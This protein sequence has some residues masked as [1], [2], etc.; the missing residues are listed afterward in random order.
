MDMTTILDAERRTSERLL[1]FIRMIQCK[2][3]C[4]ICNLQFFTKTDLNQ[5]VNENHAR[6]FF[7]CDCCNVI[8]AT[9][10]RYL[11]HNNY[12]HRHIVF[13]PY[14]YK[15]HTN[16]WRL[17]LHW[18]MHEPFECELCYNTFK[19]LSNLR[20][21]HL[22]LHHEVSFDLPYLPPQRAPIQREE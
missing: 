21:H 4:P 20:D 22:S 11:Q 17:K 18:R 5:H 12:V 3:I 9:W 6:T 10:L 16:Y 14:C 7:T 2:N 8:C 15:A 1:H 19:T 13:C